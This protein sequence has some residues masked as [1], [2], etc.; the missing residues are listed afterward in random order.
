MTGL[1]SYTYRMN[2]TPAAVTSDAPADEQ[3]LKDVPLIKTD[4]K[5]TKDTKQHD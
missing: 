5:D 2:K 3:Q 4:K 1:I